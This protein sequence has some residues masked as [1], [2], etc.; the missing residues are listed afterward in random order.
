MTRIIRL[1]ALA[2]FALWAPVA[3]AATVDLSRYVSRDT[4]IDDPNGF[5]FYDAAIDFLA[6]GDSATDITFDTFLASDPANAV[7]FFAGLPSP[8]SLSPA[9][10]VSVMAETLEFLFE[11]VDTAYL[12]KIDIMGQGYDFTDDLAYIDTTARVTLERLT[13]APVPLP[14]S[15]PF[16]LAGLGGMVVVARRKRGTKAEFC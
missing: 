14:A 9:I 8:S 16:L 15:L 2:L 11:D 7:L 13:T 12:I 3:Q 10:D 1:A 5:V 6:A 4:L